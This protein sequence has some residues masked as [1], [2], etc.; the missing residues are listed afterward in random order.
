MV[1]I[2]PGLYKPRAASFAVLYNSRPSITSV[3]ISQE[4]DWLIEVRSAYL[5]DSRHDPEF[6][7]AMMSL[8][9]QKTIHEQ[10]ER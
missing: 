4:K 2:Y 8:F 3:W 9:V 10:V 7:A 6:M 1:A 5:A